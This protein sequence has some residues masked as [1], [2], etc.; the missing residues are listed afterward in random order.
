[1]A[2]MP[3]PRAFARDRTAP[4]SHGP[5]NLE[6]TPS[7]TVTKQ[8]CEGGERRTRHVCVCGGGVVAQCRL[9][10]GQ[11]AG[12]NIIMP[13]ANNTHTR[14]HLGGCQS[15]QLLYS[16]RNEYATKP[17]GRIQVIATQRK[18]VQELP[19]VFQTSGLK[20]VPDI[21]QVVGTVA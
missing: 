19:V 2:C 12:Y 10:R 13:C 7:S 9:L 6:W 21:G 18:R 1:V 20:G 17:P 5:R 11:A 15:C 14:A 4:G 16:R 3:C 8:E